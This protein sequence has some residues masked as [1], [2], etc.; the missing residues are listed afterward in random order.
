MVLTFLQNENFSKL[1]KKKKI[2]DFPLSVP[3]IFLRTQNLCSVLSSCMVTQ[4]TKIKEFV[5]EFSLFQFIPDIRVSVAVYC[6]SLQL[7]PM[8][9]GTAKFQ[10]IIKRNLGQ[11]VERIDIAS[12]YLV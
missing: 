10:N 6:A 7:N 4:G 5:C 8:P 9:W 1:R 3:S 11:S 2:F 12:T